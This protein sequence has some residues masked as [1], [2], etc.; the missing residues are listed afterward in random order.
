MLNKQQRQFRKAMAEREK[1]QA[2]RRTYDV[3]SYRYNR[4]EI[5]VPRL[6]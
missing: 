6:F 4:F 1:E 2:N 3:Y 5:L